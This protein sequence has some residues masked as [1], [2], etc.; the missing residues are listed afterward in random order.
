[1][2]LIGGGLGDNIGEKFRLMIIAGK[3]RGSD[4]FG[5]WT[6]E[7]ILKSRD[8]SKLDR[9]P[10]GSIGLFQ[11]RLAMMGSKEYLQPFTN[12][13]TL[14][15]NG[16]IYNSPQIREYLEEGESPSRATSTAR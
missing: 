9:I 1:M 11:C 7:G 2:C 15:H 16:E 13:L 14:V 3:H 6:D 8:F 4:G 10:E 5:V 12:E